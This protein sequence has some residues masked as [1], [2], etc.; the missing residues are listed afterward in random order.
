MRITMDPRAKFQGFLVTLECF[1]YF[2]RIRIGFALKFEEICNHPSVFWIEEKTVNF[3]SPRCNDQPAGGFEHSCCRSQEARTNL[4]KKR[5]KNCGSS[6]NS[7]HPSCYPREGRLRFHP[8]S[9]TSLYCFF[10]SDFSY[11]LISCCSSINLSS[12]L[13]LPQQLL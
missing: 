1:V 4:Y 6:W 5:R 13:Y 2:R 9:H 8:S 12:G 10:S 3:N 11:S 7:R